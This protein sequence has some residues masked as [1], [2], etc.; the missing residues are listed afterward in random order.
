MKS[1]ESYDITNK[2]V[3]VYKNET[4]LISSLSSGIYERTE[5]VLLLL[6]LAL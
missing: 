5:H 4:F 3:M 1:Y 6:Q 2:K